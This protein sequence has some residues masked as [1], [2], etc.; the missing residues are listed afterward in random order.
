MAWTASG[1]TIR[2]SEGDYGVALPFSLKGFTVAA[3][4]SIKF[5]FKGEPNGT[6]ILTKDY[7]NIQNNSANLVFTAAESA[8]FKPGVY[9]Y[10]MAWYKDGNF[11]YFVIENGAFKV[12][13]VA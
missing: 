12:G 11:Q 1:T 2:M 7:S 10:N 6:V 8:L 9:C 3:A 13:D 5:E 4:D